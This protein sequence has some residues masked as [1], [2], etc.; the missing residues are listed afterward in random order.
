MDYETEQSDVLIMI[1]NHL[2]DYDTEQSIDKL[3]DG[4][5]QAL[6]R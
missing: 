3:S 1:L 6:R 4:N 2:M 5:H